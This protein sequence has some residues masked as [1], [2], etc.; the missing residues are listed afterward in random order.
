MDG[1]RNSVPEYVQQVDGMISISCIFMCQLPN[2]L[3]FFCV[4]ST[5]DLMNTYQS[6]V[7]LKI[8]ITLPTGR[9]YAR[10]DINRKPPDLWSVMPDI[11][12]WYRPW[13]SDSTHDVIARELQKWVSWYLMLCTSGD[14]LLYSALV[15]HTLCVIYIYIQYICIVIYP[16]IITTIITLVISIIIIVTILVS[17]SLSTSSNIAEFFTVTGLLPLLH[18]WRYCNGYVPKLII[19]N[20]YGSSINY[21]QHMVLLSVGLSYHYNCVQVHVVLWHANVSNL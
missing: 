2:K 18:A 19:I 20:S 3:I 11:G 9:F 16:S 12:Y 21:T 7:L 4:K 1:I 13:C 17:P 15:L 6:V 10:S 8:L 5:M 14:T